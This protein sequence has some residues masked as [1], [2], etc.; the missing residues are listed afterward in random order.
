M[1]WGTYGSDSDLLEIR[2]SSA[3]AADAPPPIYLVCTHGRHD[4]CCALRGRAVA[5]RLAEQRPD[6]VWECSHIGGDR[7]APNVLVLPQGLYYGRVEPSRARPRSSQ[8]TS[9][10]R[11]SSISSE[12]VRRFG[13][14]V[15][16][17][18]HFARLANGSRAIADLDPL[19]SRT[20]TIG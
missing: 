17:A 5:A 9:A 7:F 16:A 18:Q 4:A 8:P 15:Q 1:T 2:S 19:G 14:A 11:S 3:T 20:T 12:V 13:P 10:R 6:L